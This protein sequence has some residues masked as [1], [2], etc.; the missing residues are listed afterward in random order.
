[1][2]GA[3]IVAS[4]LALLMIAAPWGSAT[5]EPILYTIKF[6]ASGTV[7]GVPFTDEPFVFA[8]VTDTDTVTAVVEADPAQLAQLMAA[9]SFVAG[10]GF[11]IGAIVKFKQHKDNPTQ[12]WFAVEVSLP[13]PLT[14]PIVRDGALATLTID[15]ILDNTLELRTRHVAGGL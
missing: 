10:F 14:R 8:G 1:M 11:I 15:S 12:Q 9:L 7:G 13:S 3:R 5:A 4:V 2:M 6:V